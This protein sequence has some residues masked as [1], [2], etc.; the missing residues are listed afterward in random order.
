MKRNKKIFGGE[1]AG[2]K[3]GE[4]GLG[5]GGGGRVGLQRGSSP[6]CPN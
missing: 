2:L 5:V 6:Q 4:G 1:K 3:C